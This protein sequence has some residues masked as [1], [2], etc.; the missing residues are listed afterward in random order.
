MSVSSRLQLKNIKGYD[1]YLKNNN[2]NTFTLEG[3][4]NLLSLSYEDSS[5][6]LFLEVDGGPYI[7]VGYFKLSDNR[8]LSSIKR[9][10]AGKIILRF[11]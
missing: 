4:Y 11:E 3:D 6:I 1:V 10:S 5:N 9:D 8:T 7:K 2:D